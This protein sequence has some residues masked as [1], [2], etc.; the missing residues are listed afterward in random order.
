MQK[1]WLRLAGVL[2]GCTLGL[3]Q[4]RAELPDYYQVVLLT[5]NYPPFNMSVDDKNFARD[6]AIDGIA[7]DVVREMF[8]RAG[9]KY[10]LSLRF[11][12]DRIYRLTQETP[13]YGLFSVA[14]TEARKDQFKWVGPFG[15]SSWTL[16]ALPGSKLDIKTLKDA[17]RYR[18][19][20][21][22]NDVISK[23]LTAQGIPV[24]DALRDQE[25]VDKLVKGQIDIWATADPVG[26]YLAKQ[27]GVTGLQ[28]LLR[29]NEVDQYL[30]LNKDTPDE[31]VTRLKAALEQMRK[32]GVI[33]SITNNYL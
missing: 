10:S 13:N 23:T 33:D 25:N 3:T 24:I 27:Q 29:F 9:I 12:W 18:I 7:T 6:D 8:R 15:R 28:T 21:Y 17:A 2:L 16:Q 20:A 19:G 32:E 11:P 14:Y 5:E 1:L 26:R 4:A 22:R 30:A 31:V